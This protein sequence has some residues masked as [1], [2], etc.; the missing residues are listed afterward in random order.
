MWD[1]S[2]LTEAQL[3]KRD[4]TANDMGEH[5]KLAFAGNLHGEVALKKCRK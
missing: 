2:L 1:G 3:C 5:R 4:D